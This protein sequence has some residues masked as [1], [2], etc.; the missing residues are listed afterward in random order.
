MNALSDV[1][2]S[3]ALLQA[4][5][6]T[7]TSKESGNQPTSMHPRI[8]IK[9]EILE[10][11]NA[12]LSG[13]SRTS[14]EDDDTNARIVNILQGMQK[15]SNTELGQSSQFISPDDIKNMLKLKINQSNQ[16][17]DE[18]GVHNLVG[19]FGSGEQEAMVNVLTSLAMQQAK[20]LNSK[21]VANTEIHLGDNVTLSS[22]SEEVVADQGT[23][24]IDS[25]GQT[26]YVR[27][28][29]DNSLG[30][31]VS[32]VEPQLQFSTSISSSGDM[33]SQESMQSDVDVPCIPETT[34][35]QMDDNSMSNE[36]YQPCPVCGDNVSG[37]HYGIF[38]CESCKGF[39]KRTVQNNKT[40]TCHRNGDCEIS[41]GNRK[42]CP[43]CR[44]AKCVLMGMKTQAV[45][46]DRTR[47]G[48]SSYDGCSPRSRPKI[49][50]PVKKPKVK[51]P[52]STR[53]VSLEDI[54]VTLPTGEDVSG[55]QLMAILNKSGKALLQGI[56]RPVVPQILSDIVGMES[57]LCEDEAEADFPMEKISDTDPNVIMSMLQLAELKLYKLVRWA[58][59][60]PQFSSIA[61]DD[62][63]LLLQN[64]WCEI[65]TLNCC[66]KSM[67]TPSEIQ[68][69]FG[70]SIDLE[71]AVSIGHGVD[72]IISRMLSIAEHLR[73]LQVDQH[74]F[75][76][77]KVLILISPDIKGMKEPSR[78]VEHQDAI[79]EALR[80][81]TESHFP[82]T[83]TKYGQLLMRLTE[84]AKISMLTKEAL[85]SIVP[86]S[87]Q[88]CGLL[89][90]LLKGDTG[91]EDS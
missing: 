18:Q 7:L 25:V 35:S 86:P 20:S 85:N 12:S 1:S 87:L 2:I 41:R 5:S 78:V 29:T 60:L 71:K 13:G 58:R 91:K 80:Q 67:N 11:K 64:S 30:E 90:E 14:N 68:L 81:Y 8:K 27:T 4:I 3:P 74:E 43:S 19:N 37:Y 33:S 45:R 26:F 83:P 9:Q 63:I 28:S 52:Q 77:L 89:F 56:V 51:R 17:P 32:S 70:K 40:F 65:L 34:I 48:R 59:N 24:M 72:D 62:Q 15:S 69:P 66:F 36:G 46:L 79:T 42:K 31:G 88:S 6:Q 55:S 44:F 57:V 61:T 21:G 38:T 49:P 76:A 84:L 73:R 47:G 75:V 22:P 39:F 10:T 53:S 82:Q 16:K 23:L 54:N 50:V